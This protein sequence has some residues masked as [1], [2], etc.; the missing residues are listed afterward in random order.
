MASDN[1]I[2]SFN[3]IG[4]SGSTGTKQLFK[5]LKPAEQKEKTPVFFWGNVGLRRN[6]KLVSLPMGI[7]LDKSPEI[8][9]PNAPRADATPE[10]KQR[11]LEYKQLQEARIMLWNKVRE[12]MSTLKPGETITLP[13]EFEIRRVNEETESEV[14]DTTENPFAIDLEILTKS[15]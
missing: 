9:L 13:F 4:N 10:Q 2:T 5:N 1:L 12:V 8:K 6:G 14:A 3:D 11:Y 15:A 7:A